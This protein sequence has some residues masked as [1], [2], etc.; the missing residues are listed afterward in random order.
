MECCF[1]ATQK[2]IRKVKF[3]LYVIKTMYHREF[4]EDLV[5]SMPTLLNHVFMRDTHETTHRLLC[6]H[7]R[8]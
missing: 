1:Y 2:K 6:V 5:S 4:M 8:V 3:L 7:M